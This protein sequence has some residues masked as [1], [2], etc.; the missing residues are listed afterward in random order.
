MEND[1]KDLKLQHFYNLPFYILYS[2][3][4]TLIARRFGFK[5]NMKIYVIQGNQFNSI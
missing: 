4:D 5:V 2:Q 1:L 3:I